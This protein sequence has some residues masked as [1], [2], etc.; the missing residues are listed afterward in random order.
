[1]KIVYRKE[2]CI[3]CGTCVFLCSALF[4][5]KNDNKSHL[6]G[7]HRNVKTGYFELEMKN[8]DTDKIKCAKEA[9]ESC[10]VQIIIISEE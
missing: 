7:S 3:G 5:M 6:I 9:A 10:P 1:M 4:E 2:E 8:P